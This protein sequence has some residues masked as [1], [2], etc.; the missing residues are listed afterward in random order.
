M[1]PL[2]VVSRAVASLAT[3]VVPSVREP[4]AIVVLTL[5]R[6]FAEVVVERAV[7]PAILPPDTLRLVLED[8]DV[9]DA[10]SIIFLHNESLKDSV[11]G[12]E[13]R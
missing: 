1:P 3:A 13:L 5:A 6:G 10:S 8:E 11:A 2:T 12:A 9:S 4:S 7:P